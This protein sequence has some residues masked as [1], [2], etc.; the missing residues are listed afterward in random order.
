MKRI[1]ESLDDIIQYIK[2]RGVR[3]FSYDY[4]LEIINEKTPETWKKRIF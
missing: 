2:M 3:E 1:D 4:D